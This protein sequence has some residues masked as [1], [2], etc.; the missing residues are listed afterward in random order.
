MYSCHFFCIL[1]VHIAHTT[2]T[3][4]KMSE[5]CNNSH[6]QKKPIFKKDYREKANSLKINNF[7]PKKYLTNFLQIYSLKHPDS[8]IEIGSDYQKSSEF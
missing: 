6:Y 3:K 7:F 1:A 8:C 4:P 2:G 5:N